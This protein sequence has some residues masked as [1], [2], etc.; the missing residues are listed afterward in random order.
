MFLEI[1]H[2]L[3]HF[4]PVFNS[5]NCGSFNAFTRQLLQIACGHDTPIFVSYASFYVF[6]TKVTM[7]FQQR[8]T[9]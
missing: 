5:F 6:L 4:V 9:R 2:V 8:Q 7:Q 1:P 3:K